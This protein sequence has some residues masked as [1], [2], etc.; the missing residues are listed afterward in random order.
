MIKALKVASL[1]P[2]I[3]NLPVSHTEGGIW[4]MCP[5]YSIVH[6]LAALRNTQRHAYLW[7]VTGI[8]LLVL[9]QRQLLAPMALQHA[10]EDSVS[11]NR[12]LVY[13]CETPV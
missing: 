11:L 3:L 8:C 6:V 5:D 10:L 13:G 7:A 9:K 1:F 4:S 2:C 12:W